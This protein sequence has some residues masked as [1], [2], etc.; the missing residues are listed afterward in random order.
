MRQEKFSAPDLA[1]GLSRRAPVASRRRRFLL[2]A[3]VLS[4]AVHLAAALLVVL[5]PRILPQEPR[6]QE[7]G[8]VELLMVEQKG[9]EPGQADQPPADKRESAPL[10][11]KV[12]TP[13]EEAPQAEA[14][15]PAPKPNPAPPIPENAEAPPDPPREQVPAGPANPDIKPAPKQAQ[16]QPVP[17]PSPEAPVFNFEGTGSDSNAVALG[18]R[19]LPAMPDNRFRNRPPAYPT[20]AEQRGQHGA[21]VVVIHVSENGSATGV[22][23]MESSG[24]E[25]LDQAAVVAVRKWRFHPAMRAGRAIPFDMPFRFIFEPE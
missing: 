17:P 25:V 4:V 11:Q 19:I 16:A 7:Q 20:E 15:A 21:V 12:K 3:V 1:V 22:D 24:V 2:M 23:V 18:N 5:W 6:S 9:A 8:T 14:P 10:D 13:R